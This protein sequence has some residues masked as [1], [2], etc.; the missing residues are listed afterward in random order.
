MINQFD[1]WNQLRPGLSFQGNFFQRRSG[2][3]ASQALSYLILQVEN[4]WNI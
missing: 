4:S 3:V 2:E 1:L